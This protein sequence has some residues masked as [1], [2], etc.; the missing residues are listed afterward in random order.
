MD[1]GLGVRNEGN[2]MKGVKWWQRQQSR[3]IGTLLPKIPT[4]TVTGPN[5]NPQITNKKVEMKEGVRVGVTVLTGKEIV[6]TGG[7][8]G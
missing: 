6:G 2:V 3:N 5:V 4:L 7:M 8:S 1:D